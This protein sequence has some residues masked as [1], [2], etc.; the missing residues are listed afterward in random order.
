MAALNEAAVAAGEIERLRTKIDVVFESDDLFWANIKPRDVE[1]MSYREMRVPIEI[2]PGGAFRYFNPSG[3][4]MGRGG[5]PK[6]D[7]AVVQPVFM[8]EG[9]E[10]QKLAQWSTDDRRKAIINSVR[11]LTAGA[12]KE[13][14]RQLDAQLQQPGDGVV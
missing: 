8:S 9:I 10:Y 3:G 7:K 2:S 11:K 12:T 13:L 6:W 1:V 5:A 4:D 14:R